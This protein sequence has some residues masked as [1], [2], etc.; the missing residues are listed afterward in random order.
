MQDVTVEGMAMSWTAADGYPE[1]TQWKV[2]RHD[3]AGNARSFL[4]KLPAGFKMERHSHVFREHHYILDGEYSSSS[5][6]FRSGTYRMIP[7]HAEH[8][9]FHSDSGATLLVIWE[10]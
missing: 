1:G 10:I 6:S 9:P 5:K 8:G 3:A 7:T 4:L 2:L